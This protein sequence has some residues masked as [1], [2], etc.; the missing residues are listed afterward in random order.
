VGEGDVNYLNGPA[1]CT[2]RTEDVGGGWD[3][4]FENW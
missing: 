3:T 2:D 1:D 4:H